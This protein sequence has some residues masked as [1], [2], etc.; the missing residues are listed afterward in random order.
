[1]LTVA[2]RELAGY[3]TSPL[4]W[5]IF[6]LVL[7]LDGLLFNGLALE[8]ERPTSEVLWW[9]F[10]F[11]SGVTMTASVFIAMRAF[12]GERERGTLVLL[13]T[14]PIGDGALVLGKY[15]GAMAFLLLLVFSTVYM[16]LL[17]MVN[18]QLAWGQLLSGYLGLA[19]LG[20]ATMAVGVF[21]STLARTQVLA[22]VL[23]GVMVVFLLITWW[24]SHAAEPPLDGLFSHL[25]LF[26]THFKPFMDGGVHS[27]S[28]VYL[29]SIA[30]VAL[31]AS[32]RVL[33][34]RRWR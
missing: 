4:G 34:A 26:N 22:A 14:S 12:A 15:L 20:G 9:F 23:G 5:V 29:P 16:P 21:A 7:M 17:V 27:Q 19:L 3:L 18:G 30:F 8:G 32:V 24:L 25:A 10:Y 11:S 2:R 28:L 6:A 13:T 31:L 1:M 33:Q